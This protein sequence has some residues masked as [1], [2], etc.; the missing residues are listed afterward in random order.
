MYYIVA[1]LVIGVVG[2]N[3]VKQ[4]IPKIPEAFILILVGILLSYTKIFNG[5]ELEPEFFMVA[6]IA[7]LM[8][9]DGQRQSIKK[10]SRT[11]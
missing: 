5:F 1:L 2:T 10:N 6:I 4:F 8:F 7:P 11:I 3:I 9:V